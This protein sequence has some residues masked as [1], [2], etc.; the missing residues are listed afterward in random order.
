MAHSDLIVIAFEQKEDAVLARRALE[1]MRDRHL[2]G[3]EHAAEITCDEAGRTALHHHW[4]PAA[5]PHGTR[6]HLTLMLST[7]MFDLDA[8]GKRPKLVD[9]GL[10]E[11][12]LEEVMQSL[13]PNSSA[14]LIYVPNNGMASTHA[15]LNTLALFHGTVH[16][17]TVSPETEHILFNGGL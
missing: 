6:R 5:Q 16:R 7:A 2:F 17:T 13:A 15:L 10:D 1:I 3:L 11:F 8:E 14:L 12:F 4:M 9:A